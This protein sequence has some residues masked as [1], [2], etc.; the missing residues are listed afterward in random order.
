MRRLAL[1]LI[2]A[3]ATGCTTIAVATPKSTDPSQP[4]VFVT[5]ASL[6]TPYESLGPIQATRRGAL[7]LG[8]FDPVGANLQD[9]LDQVLLPEAAKAGADG[10]I[11]VRYH[12]T[13][14]TLPAKLFG[15][16]FFFLPLPAEVTITGE[17]VRLKKAQPTPPPG[18][19][20]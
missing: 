15:A 9:T 5:Q 12:A 7:A 8:F 18:A 17:L 19:P 6:G 2:A 20:L 10:V 16:L 11:N 13:T 3:S 14:Y 1:L 4:G